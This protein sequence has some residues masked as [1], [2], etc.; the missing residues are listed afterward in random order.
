MQDRRSEIRNMCAD[1][2]EIHWRDE[3]GRQHSQTALLEDIS[4]SGACLQV[5]QALPSGV[6]VRWEC[7]NQ[8]FI[9]RVQHC[10]YRE[11]GYFAGVRFSPATLWSKKTYRPR[12]L[13]DFEKFIAKARGASQD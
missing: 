4:S 8:Q 3:K 13:L 1:M 12:H 7:P 2:L 6:V 10:A 11:I 5:E 9:G